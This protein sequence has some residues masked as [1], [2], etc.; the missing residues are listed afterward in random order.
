MVFSNF[1]GQERKL[2]GSEKIGELRWFKGVEKLLRVRI[3][4]QGAV[5]LK[6]R[7]GEL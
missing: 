4:Y 3:G 5:G 7:F 6:G 2:R 1:N